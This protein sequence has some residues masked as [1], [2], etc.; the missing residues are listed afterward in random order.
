MSLINVRKKSV[1]LDTIYH[2]N[3]P[4]PETPLLTAAAYAVVANPFAGRYE[5]NLKDFMTEAR[6]LGE[7]LTEDLIKAV[8]GA[9]KVQAFGKGA[10]VGVNGELEHGAI[11]HEA[12]GWPLRKAVDGKAIVPAAKVVASAGYRLPVPLFH[13]DASF[14]RSHFNTVEIGSI[15]APRPNELLFGLVVATGGRIHDRLG[16]LRPEEISV[17]DGQR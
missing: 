14:V 1:V 17:H 8:G 4:A 15:D 6:A 9:E 7:Q 2:E 10:I 3:G 13:I 5:E 16:G 12:G 11:W